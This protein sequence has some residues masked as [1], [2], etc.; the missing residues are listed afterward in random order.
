M[1]L[2]YL[3]RNGDI[4]TDGRPRWNAMRLSDPPRKAVTSYMQMLSNYRA[5]IEYHAL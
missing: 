1:A 4:V 3:R 2:T 5:R